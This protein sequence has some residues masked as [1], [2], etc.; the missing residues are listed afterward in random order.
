MRV[1]MKIGDSYFAIYALLN[2][3]WTGRTCID[4][5]LNDHKYLNFWMPM[6]QKIIAYEANPYC[7]EHIIQ[8]MDV[9]KYTNCTVIGKAASNKVGTAILNCN[10]VDS[11]YSTLEKIG[12]GEKDKWSLSKKLEVELTTL[13]N[14]H[15]NKTTDLDFIKIDAERHDNKVLLGAEKTIAQ[16]QPLVHVEHFNEETKEIFEKFNYKSFV[17]FHFRLGLWGVPNNKA[18]LFKKWLANEN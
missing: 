1:E 11:G 15:Y 9:E 14:D 6:F 7:Y 12:I 17:P 8:N 16:N 18:H 4:V 3:N 13:D 5:G 2:G 10:K